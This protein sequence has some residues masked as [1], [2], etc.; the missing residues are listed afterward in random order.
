MVQRGAF[1]G[2][3]RVS[4][5]CLLASR[6]NLRASVRWMRARRGSS[7]A[8]RTASRTAPAASS[9]VSAAA[10]GSSAPRISAPGA[11]DLLGVECRG[12]RRASACRGSW[13]ASASAVRSAVN[14]RSARCRLSRRARCPVVVPFLV[15]PEQRGEPSLLPR[16]LPFLR[17]AQ[18]LLGAGQF[19]PQVG[20]PLPDG[21]ERRWHVGDGRGPG[22]TAVRRGP[23]RAGQQGAPSGVEPGRR[24]TRRPPTARRPWPRAAAA[25]PGSAVPPR[26]VPPPRRG[27]GC[28]AGRPAR[29][30]GRR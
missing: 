5:A 27:G 15:Q 6:T 21:S 29:R 8:R 22:R 24:R 1:P 10:Y 11:A 23:C 20:E 13:R 25:A 14:R 18:G 30:A 17:V 3:S 19:L 9:A 16:G 28:R 4:C 2:P 12:D 7:A 26:P